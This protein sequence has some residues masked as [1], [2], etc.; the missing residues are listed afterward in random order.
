M[1]N[2]AWGIAGRTVLITGAARGIGAETARLLTQAGA[3]VALV[4]LRADE[5]AT[6]ATR[7]GSR[8]AA[9]EAD[10]TDVP[11]L[12]RAIGSVADHFGGIDAVVANAGVAH[13]E[14]VAA[15]DPVSF[16][17]TIDV[18]LVGPWNTVRLALPHVRSR[19]GYVLCVASIAAAVHPAMHGAYAAS[20]AGVEALSDVLRIEVAADG[21]DV[22]VAY[23]PYIDTPMVR[24]AFGSP[25]G[26]DLESRLKYP[27]NRR[28]PVER[29]GA[30]MVD[31][32]VGRRR[33]VYTP[34]WVR[35]ALLLRGVAPR[36]V[37]AQMRDIGAHEVV[38]RYEREAANAYR[39]AAVAAR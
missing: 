38:A 4:D 29:A 26:Q 36:L 6:V 31:G 2:Q 17:Q 8:A 37:E 27:L 23:F 22:G 39:E 5:L 33:R 35:A 18:N 11:A 30:A 16:R 9:F 24:D 19:R 1:S 12:E 14:S 3:K 32:I 7:L 34:R 10:V 28:V 15:G 25:L 21:V 13:L 20:K